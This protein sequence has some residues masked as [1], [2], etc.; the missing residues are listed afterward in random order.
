MNELITTKTFIIRKDK[1]SIA[2]DRTTENDNIRI[3]NC[4]IPALD[5]IG[6]DQ[7]FSILRNHALKVTLGSKIG[8]PLV[9]THGFET[10]LQARHQFP[11]F[12]FESVFLFYDTDYTSIEFE[13]ITRDASKPQL[14]FEISFIKTDTLKERK[15]HDAVGMGIMST[16][17]IL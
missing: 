7:W 9:N 8:Q 1:F 15:T 13:V 12:K 11:T 10:F 16:S 17:D 3:I 6:K 14:N 4:V 2:F 5:G